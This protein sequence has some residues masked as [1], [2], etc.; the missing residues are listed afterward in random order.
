MSRD[1]DAATALRCEWLDLLA[2]NGMD[3]AKASPIIERLIQCLQDD[4]GGDVIYIPV[5]RR[6]YPM[7]RIRADLEAG[8]A[9]RAICRRYR[10]DRRTLYRLLDEA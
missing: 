8:L 3:Q 9:I 7:D 4:R 5:R 6:H 2:R 1:I 10:M